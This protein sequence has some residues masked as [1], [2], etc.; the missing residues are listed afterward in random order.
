MVDD[1]KK[2]PKSIP[3]NMICMDKLYDILNHSQD[4]IFVINA[5]GMV[6]YVNQACENN[7]GLKPFDIIGRYAQELVAEGYYSPSIAPFVFKEKKRVTLSQETR[8]GKKLVVTATPILDKDQ[9]IEYIIM[10]ARDISEIQTLKCDLAE[11]KRLVQKYKQE[12]EELRKKEYL[13]DHLIVQSKS[14]LECV[15]L[16]QKISAADSIVLLLGESG[17]GKNVMAKYIHQISNRRK[18]PFKC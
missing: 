12:V 13:T 14:M 15:E 8:M 9:N 17:T 2:S 5:E 4:E 10:N 6:V 7:Y 18:G 11:T 1:A 3:K 16:V